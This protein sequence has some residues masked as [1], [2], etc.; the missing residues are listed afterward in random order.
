MKE[1]KYLCPKC[2]R[3]I[4]GKDIMSLNHWSG[5]EMGKCM[6]CGYESIATDFKLLETKQGEGLN[7]ELK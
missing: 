2:K 4:S 6:P 3:I 5:K 1:Y 7:K